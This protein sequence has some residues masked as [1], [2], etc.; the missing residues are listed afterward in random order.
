MSADK[1]NKLFRVAGKEIS[2]YGTK[3]EKGIGIGLLLVKQFADENDADIKIWSELGSGTEFII[4][5]KRS[6]SEPE[7]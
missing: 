2:S 7:A 5:F 4:S 3:N 1:I 6:N